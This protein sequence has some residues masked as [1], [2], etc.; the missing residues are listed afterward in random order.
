MRS[1]S[2]RALPRSPD[3]LLTGVA[4]QPSLD[5]IPA[6]MRGLNVQ[7]PAEPRILADPPDYNYGFYFL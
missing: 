5:L 7:H 1:A 2:P 3:R 4:H 6:R